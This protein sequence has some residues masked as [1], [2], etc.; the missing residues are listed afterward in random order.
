MYT[1]LWCGTLSGVYILSVFP[2]PAEPV[3]AIT[4]A[5]GILLCSIHV[6]WR[7]ASHRRTLNIAGRLLPER[8]FKPVSDAVASIHFEPNHIIRVAIL[9]F[10]ANCLSIL[11]FFMVGRTAAPETGAWVYFLLCPLIFISTAIPVSP[12]GIGVGETAASL[13]FHAFHIENGAMMM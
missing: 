13:L 7:F 6:I 12:G 4:V 2:E 8:Y 3:Y 1:L 10:T 5:S 11:A 9:S